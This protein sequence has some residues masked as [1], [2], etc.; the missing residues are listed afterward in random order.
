LELKLL[1]SNKLTAIFQ[2]GTELASI[3]AASRKTSQTSLKKV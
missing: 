2:E 3:L 1:P